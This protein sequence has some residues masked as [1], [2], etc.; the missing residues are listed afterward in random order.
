[1]SRIVGPGFRTGVYVD[2]RCFSPHCG[3]FSH[4]SF[5]FSHESFDFSHE[6]F[7]FSHK[8]FTVL[9]EDQKNAIN[10]NGMLS[11]WLAGTDPA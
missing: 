9:A 7:D 2:L 3:D 11:F 1:M 6:S 4:E 8:S 5:D 10:I